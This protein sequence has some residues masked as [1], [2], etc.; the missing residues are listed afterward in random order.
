MK[1]FS[2]R[3][4]SFRLTLFCHSY[5]YS[6]CFCDLLALHMHRNH[7]NRGGRQGQRPTRHTRNNPMYDDLFASS[8]ALSKTSSDSLPVIATPGR[9]EPIAAPMPTEIVRR[10]LSDYARPVVQRQTT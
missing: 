6:C 7:R 10:R 3:H 1:H 2:F 9:G 4:H 5:I 8:R